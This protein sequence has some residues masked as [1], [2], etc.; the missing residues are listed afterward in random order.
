MTQKNL[1]RAVRRKQTIIFF[2]PYLRFFYHHIFYYFIFYSIYLLLLC[3]TQKKAHYHGEEKD[4]KLVHVRQFPGE[5]SSMK[6]TFPHFRFN[7]TFNLGYCPE[8]F[9]ITK[10]AFISGFSGFSS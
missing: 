6:Q 4:P 7:L 10:K 8:V 1:T 5:L 3:C 2:W 9:E